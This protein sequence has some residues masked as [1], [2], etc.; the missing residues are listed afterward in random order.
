MVHAQYALTRAYAGPL[1]HSMPGVYRDIHESCCEVVGC[2]KR[3]PHL[4]EL[5]MADKSIC[6]K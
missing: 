3:K 1:Y 6:I 2:V 4:S 5:Y